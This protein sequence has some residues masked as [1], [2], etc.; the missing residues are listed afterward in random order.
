[1]FRYVH[2]MDYMRWGGGNF[3]IMMGLLFLV[4]VGMLVYIVVKVS[5]KGIE[6]EDQSI[7]RKADDALS[8]LDIRFARGEINKDEYLEKKELIIGSNSRM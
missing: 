8:V 3:S 4:V 7:L 2:G 6:K 5:K 1:M